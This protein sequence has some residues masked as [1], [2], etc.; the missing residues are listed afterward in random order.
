MGFK[1]DAH[2]FTLVGSAALLVYAIAILLVPGEMP[3]LVT[4][5]INAI[6]AYYLYKRAESDILRF[7]EA[8]AQVTT[9]NWFVG[10]LLGLGATLFHR[11]M[12][13]GLAVLVSTLAFL[14]GVP[15]P[16]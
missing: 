10:V 13:F 8:S 12:Y 15:I 14:A 1:R 11:I 4:G 3:S 7:E 5:G 16:D 6:A 2:K 9:A